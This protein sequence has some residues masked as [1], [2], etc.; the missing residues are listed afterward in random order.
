V[1][2]GRLIGQRRRGIYRR[3]A[4]LLAVLVVGGAVVAHH[5]MPEM[6]GMAASVTCMAVLGV[7]VAFAVAKVLRR[8]VGPIS[9]LKPPSHAAPLRDAFS[10]PARAGPLY[11]TL[12]VLRN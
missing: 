6:A 5:T 2:V 4:T 9:L 7:A 3:L 10:V 1:T 12:L 8:P 11:L